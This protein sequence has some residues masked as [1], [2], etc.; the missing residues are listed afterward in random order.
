M[1]GENISGVICSAPLVGFGPTVDK[2]YLV[3]YLVKNYLC[4]IFPTFVISSNVQPSHLSRNPEIVK[5][6]I[7]NP[8]ITSYA[9]LRTGADVFQ[10]VEYFETFNGSEINTPFLIT[11][12]TADVICDMEK[13]KNLFD[14]MSVKDKHFILYPGFYHELHNEPEWKEVAENYISWILKRK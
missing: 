13:A 1:E 4:K 11:F 14:K 2:S 5:S 8:D 12:G 10:M 6:Y 9:S 7:S 3:K